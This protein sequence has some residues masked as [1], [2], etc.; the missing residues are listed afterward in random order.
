MIES[1]P[2]NIPPNASIH[3]S[4]ATETRQESQNEAKIGSRGRKSNLP[5]LRPRIEREERRTEEREDGK[6][7]QSEEI[8]DEKP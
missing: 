6:N 5:T 4:L 3:T 7:P 2:T 8:K 1:D